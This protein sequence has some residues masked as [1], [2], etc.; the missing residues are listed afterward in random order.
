MEAQG[1]VDMWNRSFEKNSLRYVDF[2]GDGDCSSH[3]DVVKAKP[4]GD[5]GRFYA[6]DVKVVST[7][8]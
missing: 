2:V 8:L 3:R 4:Y 5:N 1:A 7:R 6:R